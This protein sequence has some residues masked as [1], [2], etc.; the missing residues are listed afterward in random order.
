MVRH[1]GQHRGLDLVDDKDIDEPEQIAG[2]W[3]RGC[4]V[5][6]AKGLPAPGDPERVVDRLERDLELGKEQIGGFD[7]R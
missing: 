5:E 4:R 2:D 7:A 1:A 3:P 6:H